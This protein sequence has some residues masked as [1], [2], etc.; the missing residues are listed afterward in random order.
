MSAVCVGGTLYTR[1]RE[2]I[3][4]IRAAGPLRAL[5]AVGH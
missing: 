5:A 4:A 2:Q 1:H 3:D